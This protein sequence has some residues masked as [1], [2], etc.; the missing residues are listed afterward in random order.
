MTHPGASS[1]SLPQQSQNLKVIMQTEGEKQAG[2]QAGQEVRQVK[3]ARGIPR[4]SVIAA[5]PE[6]HADISLIRP[7]LPSVTLP[8]TGKAGSMSAPHPL[9]PWAYT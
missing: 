3:P 7:A 4:S 5:I 8:V 2:R 1:R 9:D 6:G